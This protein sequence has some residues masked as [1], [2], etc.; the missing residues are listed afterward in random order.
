MTHKT[1]VGV[2]VA[3][4]TLVA[5]CPAAMA[6]SLKAEAGE[7]VITVGASGGEDGEFEAAAVDEKAGSVTL[8]DGQISVRLLEAWADALAG[9]AAAPTVVLEEID[10]D[11]RPMSRVTVTGI[12]RELEVEGKSIK[13]C[14]LELLELAETVEAEGEHG[15][16]IYII[17]VGDD[18]E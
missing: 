12:P 17:Y 1:I 9:R 4:F 13:A 7:F 5:L 3:L 11:G 14:Q 2:S 16:M 6:Q 8:Y 18:D 15:I 10:E